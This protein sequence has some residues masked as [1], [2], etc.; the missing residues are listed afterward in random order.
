MVYT[1]IY[2][3]YH[4]Q[5]SGIRVFAQF[6]LNFLFQ[7]VESMFEQIRSKCTY[8]KSI[9]VYGH[10]S[11]SWMSMLNIIY[12]YM[13]LHLAYFIKIG[14]KNM[15]FPDRISELLSTL[16]SDNR[17]FGNDQS[18]VLSSGL[19]SIAPPFCMLYIY[20]YLCDLAWMIGRNYPLVIFPSDLFDKVFHAG[21]IFSLLYWSL[22]NHNHVCVRRANSKIQVRQLV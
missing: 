1:F 5:W 3:R 9:V 17:R 15:G 2:L 13:W 6:F 20:G 19:V 11:L 18:S 12:L 7:L 16:K 21:V 10:E 22:I 4:G 14:S 8:T